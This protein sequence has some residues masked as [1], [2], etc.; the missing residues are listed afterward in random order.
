MSM[1]F[2][3]GTIKWFNTAKAYGFI[4]RQSGGDIFLTVAAINESGRWLLQAGEQ[5]EYSILEG[6]KGV[7][8]DNVR[9]VVASA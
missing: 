7:Q 2:E 1:N 8:A 4:T 6:P 5:V 9:H 3:R